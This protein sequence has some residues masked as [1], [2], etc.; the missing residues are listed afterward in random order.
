MEEICLEA[1]QKRL[2]EMREMALTLA[3]K[4]ADFETIVHCKI[5]LKEP[6]PPK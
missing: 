2:Q 1:V 6:K 5:H 4:I 3:E